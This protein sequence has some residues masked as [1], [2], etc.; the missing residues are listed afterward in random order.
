MDQAQLE[1]LTSKFL[2]GGLIFIRILGMMAAAPVFRSVAINAKVKVFLAA[3]MALIMTNVYAESQP[4]IEFDVFN[5][6]VIA[7]KEFFFG[8][9]IGFSANMV[10]FAARFAGG[11][12]DMEMGYNTSM[13]FDPTNINPT[14]VG[15]FKDLIT[16]MLFFFINGHHYL[17]ESLHA[18]FH[19]VPISKFFISDITVRHLTAMMVTVFVLAMKF[20]AP[21]LV[22]LF[23]A[24]L[25]LALLARVAPQTN[26]F[27]LSF[28]VKIIVGLSMLLLS[29]PIM[30]YII[31]W[32]LENFQSQTLEIIMSLNPVNVA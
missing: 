14:L 23:S 24:N 2:I 4:V 18:S 26:I 22:A 20:A 6:S 15:E 29:L 28:Q 30:V 25:S 7:L 21:V 17:I 19:I 3:V 5:V 12:I 13:L 8:V 32:A 11:L 10:F 16:L 1:I 31:K 27:I 9:L